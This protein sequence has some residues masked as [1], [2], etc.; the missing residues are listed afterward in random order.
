MKHASPVLAAIAAAL[1]VVTPGLVGPAQAGDFDGAYVGAG[2]SA[3]FNAPI[4][5]DYEGSAFIGYNW[6]FGNQ[7]VAGGELDLSYN[8]KSLWGAD[9]TTSTLDGRLGFLANDAVM[10]YGRAGGGYTS[11]GVGSYVWDVG[12]GAEYM[13]NNGMTVRG[14]FDRVDPFEVGMDTQM[15][16]R[17]GVVMNF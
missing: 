6:D 11:G 13:M 5:P 16:G 12:V 9:A 10:V 17:L 15:N 3:G 8:P 2:L 7:I 14:E 4:V 1:S